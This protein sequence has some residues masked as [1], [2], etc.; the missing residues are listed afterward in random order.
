MQV[1]QRVGRVGGHRHGARRAARL[2]RRDD[3]GHPALLG[4]RLLVAAAGLLGHAVQAALG[5]LE[6]G[7]EQLGLD[8]L[9]VAGA[10]RR[11]P[12][13][14]RRWRRGG[15]A[16]RGRWRRP[17][18]C[19]PGTGCPGPRPRWAPRTRPAM[20]W[21]SI[22]S[23]TRFE[24]PIGLR[25]ALEAL[26]DD[27]HDGDVGLDGRERVVGRLGARARQR[28]EQR[29]LARVG[30]ADDPDLHR[31]AL[32]MA[33]PSSAPGGDVGGVVHAEV[34][35]RARHRRRRRVERR[36]GQQ[37]PVGARGGER[38]RG[39]RR[40]EAEPGRGGDE[41]GQ[42]GERRAAAPEDRL[43][44]RVDGVGRS[45]DHERARR[46]RARRGRSTS[47]PTV[48][49]ASHS[50]ACSPR[51]E[52]RATSVAG[53]RPRR[54]AREPVEAQVGAGDRAPHGDAATRSRSPIARCDAR[55]V[56]VGD[57]AGRQV[58]RDH[59]PGADHGVVADGRRPGRR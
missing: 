59:R 36:G 32:P 19:W 45:Y 20:S 54:G 31:A 58:A 16:R 34:D 14:A 40:G 43:D 33:S 56:A 35:P 1:A 52:K 7:V 27:R 28:V 12:R 47:A 8:R 50:A 46:Q 38:R 23:C 22:V 10:G 42:V 57:D 3:L 17:R 6:V 18:G 4:L 39:V 15:R 41:R 55:G 11:R 53:R 29:R 21:K 26:V 30:H 24:A 44:R 2:Q 13:G 25:D 48:P 49:R 51:R 9:D 5:L 37:A